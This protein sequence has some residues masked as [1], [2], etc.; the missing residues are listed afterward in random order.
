MNKKRSVKKIDESLF[1]RTYDFKKKIHFENVRAVESMLAS[2]L[3]SK[4]E[5][6]LICNESSSKVMMV[7]GMPYTE[8]IKCGFLQ[9][10]L[11]PTDQFLFDYYQ[12]IK[13]LTSQQSQIYLAEV[14]D[15]E[16]MRR[17]QNISG[18][19]IDFITNLISFDKDSLWVDIG[20]GKG[21][22]L[23]IVQEKGFR[24]LGIDSSL[25]AVKYA[26]S[27]GIETL[28]MYVDET[29]IIPAL[30]DAHVVSLFNILE[31]TLQPRE[32]LGNIV[33][34]MPRFSYLVIEVPRY[35]SISTVIQKTGVIF[36][37]RHIYPIE[38]LNIFSDHS[39]RLL[40]DNLEMT[41]I[42]TWHFGC[43]AISLFDYFNQ[44]N[45]LSMSNQFE[46]S[47]DSINLLQKSI[48]S[49]GLSDIMLI[50]AQKS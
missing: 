10:N 12:G 27:H 9:A 6:C 17:I 36:N 25:E 14:T 24:C 39:M 22:N 16:N 33:R 37:Y 48:D 40:L 20:S 8:C 47:L 32:F 35:N 28:E 23:V 50:V 31:H 38:H 29:Q 1:R 30:A 44:S 34:Q 18:P 7:C 13:E 15:F 3:Y 11:R 5:F 46:D 45:F 21:D 43:D 42:D 2:G 4:S 26:N 49:Q 41:Y 19:K